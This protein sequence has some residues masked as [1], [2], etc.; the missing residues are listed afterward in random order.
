MELYKKRTF[1]NQ[2][3]DTI[4]FFKSYGKNFFKQFF[5]INGIP[6][7]LL[8][9]ISF[10]L[11]KVFFEAAFLG[12]NS[13]GDNNTLSYFNDNMPLIIIMGLVIVILFFVLNAINF[14]YPIAYFQ[15][16]EKN[17]VPTN[18]DFGDFYKNNVK[19]MLLFFGA[20]FLFTMI[21]GIIYALLFFMP[22]LAI[23]FIMLMIIILPF[24]YGVMM[25]TFYVYLNSE[26]TGFIT[27]TKI[28]FEYYT[29]DLI[30]NVGATII[31]YVIVQTLVSIITFVV[32]FVLALVFFVGMDSMNMM[33]SNTAT[34]VSIIVTLV[35]A[36]SLVSSIFFNNLMVVHQGMIYYSNQNEI[37]NIKVMSD[38]DQ[39]G[40]SD[41]E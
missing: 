25:Q 15:F 41:E 33:D 39:I 9:L 11:I 12:F 38:I 27:S 30:P 19:K 22:F 10:L 18:E 2:F 35:F 8:V 31:M 26:N 23:L 7:I 1:G 21:F 20:I 6:I 4:E 14:T 40:L 37:K 13:Y 29:K 3:N 32:Y 28:G 24:L 17:I 34:T 36:L 5:I 16:A